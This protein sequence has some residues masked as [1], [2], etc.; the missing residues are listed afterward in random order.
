MCGPVLPGNSAKATEWHPLTIKIGTAAGGSFRTDEDTMLVLKPQ[1]LGSEGGNREVKFLLQILL[2]YLGSEQS[3]TAAEHIRQIDGEQGLLE[4]SQHRDF[5]CQLS[6]G[7]LLWYWCQGKFCYWNLHF[8]E[9]LA[10]QV[11][12]LRSKG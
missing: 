10:T 2:R 11:L 3:R 9:P 6:T 7:R 4:D 1:P 8:R 12:N 5:Q